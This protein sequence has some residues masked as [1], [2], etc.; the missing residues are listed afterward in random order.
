MHGRGQGHDTPLH[1]AQNV[2]KLL[3][4]HGADVDAREHYEFT[5]LHRAKN[6]A[7]VKLLLDHG[8][9]VRVRDG[10]HETPLH[11]ARNVAMARLLVNRGAYVTA[12]N[13]RGQNALHYAAMKA[14]LDLCMFLVSRGLYQNIADNEGKTALTLYG[15][16]LSPPL[17]DEQKKRRPLSSS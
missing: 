15:H 10:Y 11:C 14:R 7:L 2:A 9:D 12:V 1:W 13:M 6:E 3:L 16:R 8:A 17:T 4:N 5:P